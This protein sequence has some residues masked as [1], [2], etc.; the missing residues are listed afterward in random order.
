VRYASRYYALHNT[1][2]RHQCNTGANISPT[3]NTMTR[4]IMTIRR[5]LYIMTSFETSYGL[6][7]KMPNAYVWAYLPS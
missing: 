5:P 7:S 6:V 3:A 1:I 4:G 2:F